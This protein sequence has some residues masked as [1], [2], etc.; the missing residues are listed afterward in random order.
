MSCLI[1]TETPIRWKKLTTWRPDYTHDISCHNSENWPQRNGNNL[2]LELKPDH[3]KPPRGHWSDGRWPTWRRQSEP[4][5]PLLHVAASLCLKVLVPLV[6]SGGESAF[7]QTDAHPH[8][9][10]LPASDIKQT[11]LSTNPDCLLALEWW[12]A[13]PHICEN[14]KRC[15]DS[16]RQED[17]GLP[18]FPR[19]FQQCEKDNPL[20]CLD[21]VLLFSFLCKWIYSLTDAG[22]WWQHKLK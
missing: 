21:T 6:I 15:Q 19:C 9:L 1:D 2:S 20:S 4:T 17:V 22:R 18:A 7:G 11:F 8:P 10:Q 12:A 13:G 3:L 14:S 5:V 16:S